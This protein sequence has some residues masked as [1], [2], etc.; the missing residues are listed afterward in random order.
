[1]Y[2]SI[3]RLLRLHHDG[4]SIELSN[5]DCKFM[6]IE[7]KRPWGRCCNHHMKMPQSICSQRL[8]VGSSNCYSKTMKFGSWLI[9]F[10]QQSCWQ[11]NLRCRPHTPLL[12]NFDGYKHTSLSFW[13]VWPKCP[14]HICNCV[15]SM[16]MSGVFEKLPWEDAARPADVYTIAQRCWKTVRLCLWVCKLIWYLCCSPFNHNDHWWIWLSS[17]KESGLQRMVE[18]QG[19]PIPEL[20]YWEDVLQKS[21]SWVHIYKSHHIT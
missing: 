7:N 10:V 14:S 2:R 3:K 8:V 13:T 16:S 4:E 1:M 11:W 18:D 6:R 9:E 20:V 19:Q 12:R 15:T 17:A 21:K 5:C